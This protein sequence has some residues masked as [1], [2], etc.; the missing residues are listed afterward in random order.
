MKNRKIFSIRYKLV[1]V[2]SIFFT[3]FIIGFLIINNIFLERFFL[4]RLENDMKGYAEIVS[5]SYDDFWGNLEKRE[6]ITFEKSRFSGYKIEIADNNGNV[7]HSSVPEFP[8]MDSYKL[9]SDYLEHFLR[10]I[11]GMKMGDYNYEVLEQTNHKAS[12][13]ILI[14]KREDMNYLVVSEQITNIKGNMEIAKEFFLIAGTILTIIGLFITYVLSKTITNPIIKISKQAKEIV[15]FDFSSRYT[16]QI[17]D[18]I[19]NL[20]IHMNQI[21]EELKNRIEELGYINEKL[22]DDMSLQQRFLASISHEFMSP[23]GIIKGY[24][25]SIKL[26]YY[27]NETEKNEYVD[28]ILEESDCLAALAEDMIML[29]RLNRR[30][31]VLNKEEVNLSKVLNGVCLKKRD[32]YKESSV[33]MVLEIQENINFLC[34]KTRM[35]QIFNNLLDNG[36]RYTSHPWNLVIKMYQDMKGIHLTVVNSC[37][38]LNEQDIE[39]V[40]MPFYRFEESHSKLTGGHGLGL[41]ITKALVE[42]Q[43]GM[44]NAS[45]NNGEFH[46]EIE[47]FIF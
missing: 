42:A 6:A 4:W 34:D 39:Q 41:S 46:L 29:S 7:I 24:A 28:Y 5:E 27:A 30:T 19:G 44:I 8:E 12:Q 10:E 40:F 25:E 21:S 16:G 14:L 32:Q 18:E 37:N 20:G 45:Y 36:Y 35:S 1:I 22:I 3:L 17:T 13:I 31:F 9:Q 26:N 43:G 11:T 2:A 33:H 38:P 23:V 15:G 47:M